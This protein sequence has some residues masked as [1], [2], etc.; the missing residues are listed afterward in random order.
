LEFIAAVITVWVPILDGSI[1]PTSC[2]LAL[3][4]NSSAVGW[5]HK[6]NVN[7][8]HTEPFEIATRHFTSLLMAANSCLRSQ[9]FKGIYNKIADALSCKFDLSDTNLT[10]FNCTHYFDQVLST[11]H[12]APLLP[13]VSSWMIWFLQRIKEQRVSL[14]APTQKKHASGQGGRP[15]ASSSQTSMTSSCESFPPAM[16]THMFGAFATAL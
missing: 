6:A 3:G 2:I 13:L 10:S 7:E 11:F 1:T 16:R 4:D 5:L 15:T 14:L 8:S 9:H 12:I